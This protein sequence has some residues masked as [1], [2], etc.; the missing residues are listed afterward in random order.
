MTIRKSVC[1][2]LTLLLVLGLFS[3]GVAAKTGCK[4]QAC[5]QMF[6]DGSQPSGKHM[7]NSL[8]A[9]CCANPH[10]V[11]C[12]FERSR[13]IIAQHLCIS[14]GR[15]ENNYFAGVLA[16]ARG[17]LIR[18]RLPTDFYP[19]ELYLLSQSTPI[20]LRNQTLIV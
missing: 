19:S 20:Y 15:L 10:T 16:K 13:K 14:S 1:V 7:A 11:P 12:E 9:D 5:K 3:T 18:D 2:L 17:D 8:L 6:M 4:D